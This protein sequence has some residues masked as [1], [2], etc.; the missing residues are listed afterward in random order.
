TDAT[1]AADYLVRKGVPFREAHGIIGRI[2][3]AC[4]EQ[5]KGIAEL[6]L[7]ELQQ[8]DPHFEADIY[9]ALQLDNVVSRRETD[10]APG[11]AAMEK[12]L[13]GNRRFL[14]LYDEYLKDREGRNNE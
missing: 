3:R 14:R 8:F 2:V 12:E 9:E 5:D 10:G 11:P 13:E 1:D 6:S 4:I 7:T